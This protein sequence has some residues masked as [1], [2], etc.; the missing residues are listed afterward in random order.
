MEE[1]GTALGTAYQIK[2]AESINPIIG[3]GP[4]ELTCP[5]NRKKDQCRLIHLK[6]Y[7]RDF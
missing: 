7:F 3:S 1:D 6:N 2:K 4:E 5:H